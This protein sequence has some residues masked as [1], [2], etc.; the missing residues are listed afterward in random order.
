MGNE[1]K[2]RKI[3]LYE[4]LLWAIGIV[5]IIVILFNICVANFFRSGRWFPFNFSQSEVI[6]KDKLEQAYLRAVKDAEIAEPAEISRELTPIVYHNPELIWQGN[7]GMSPL[8]VVTWASPG[9]YDE[10]VTDQKSEG[11]VWVTV[12]PE[13]KNFCKKLNL[14][15]ERLTLRLEQLLG[16]PPNDGKTDFVEIWVDLDDLFRPSPDPEISDREAELDFPQSDKFLTL[17]ADHITWFN[18]TRG[19]SYKNRGYPWTRLG[20]TYDWGNQENEIG[21]SE[22]VIKDGAALKIYSV[23]KTDTYCN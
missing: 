21:L 13:V 4:K 5:L 11:D 14:S 1:T 2:T 15:S 20:Y 9:K 19:I 3:T 6:S 22:F 8:L 17:A 7:P 10:K 23:V 12:A 18:K 16:L